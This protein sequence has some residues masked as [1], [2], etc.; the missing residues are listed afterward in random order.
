MCIYYIASWL[1]CLSENLVFY[2]YDKFIIHSCLFS[3]NTPS[4]CTAFQKYCKDLQMWNACILLNVKYA[5]AFIT[6]KFLQVSYIIIIII[7]MVI[8]KCYF[9]GE[10]IALS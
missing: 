10:L 8:F 4:T 7:I 2:E 5:T 9:S 3:V 1:V 6:D